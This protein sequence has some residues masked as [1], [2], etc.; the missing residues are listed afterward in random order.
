MSSS[1]D[2]SESKT[3]SIVAPLKDQDVRN[4]FPTISRL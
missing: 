1:I 4:L 2:E 3:A